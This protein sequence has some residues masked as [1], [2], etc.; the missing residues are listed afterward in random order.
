M[1]RVLLLTYLLAQEAAR[2]HLD[3][4]E[5]LPRDI[6]ASETL[7]SKMIV[8]ELFLDEKMISRQLRSSQL[9]QSSFTSYFG[10]RR[11]DVQNPGHYIKSS[12]SGS[13][14][15][16]N[17]LLDQ[18]ID[19][20]AFSLHHAQPITG[21]GQTETLF[22]V[23]AILRRMPLKLLHRATGWQTSEVQKLE[24]RVK[25][26]DFVQKHRTEARRC[27][28]HAT[29]IFDSIRRCRLLACYDV[30][31]LMVAVCYIYCYCDLRLDGNDGGDVDAGP[32]ANPQTQS[33]RAVVRLDQLRDKSTIEAWITG[34]SE[35]EVIHLTGV[36]LL[37]G[38]DQGSR[39]LRAVERALEQQVAWRGFSLAFAG[40]FA[41]L[42][43]GE[44][45]SM[46]KSK[47]G[48]DSA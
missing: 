23:L 20:L 34:G 31:S 9:L 40:S 37:D 5:V 35:T 41:Q 38:P 28:W 7:V 27:L 46:P 13:G 25:L 12:L 18:S 43:R 29:C 21:S 11:Q 24:A 4:N 30:F 33:Q 26:K 16:D 42:R 6:S 39:F 48:E 32:Q 3:L 17:L 47:E 1:D 14:K 44:T 36:G 2:Q 8:L 10:P 22:H 19:L 45:P 15:N